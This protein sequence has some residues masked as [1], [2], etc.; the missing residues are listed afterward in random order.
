MNTY[1]E[2]LSGPDK[3][4]VYQIRPTLRIGSGKYDLSI[5]DPDLPQ[6]HSQVLLNAKNQMVLVCT[7]AVFEIRI[8]GSSVKKVALVHGMTLQIGSTHLKVSISSI[9]IIGAVDPLAPKRDPLTRPNKVRTPEDSVENTK[10]LSIVVDSPKSH[11][12]KGLREFSKTVTNETATNSFKLF[13]VPLLL[14]LETG[15]QADDEY[16]VSWGPRDF[17]PMALEFPIEFPPFPGVLFTLSPSETG[18]VVFSTKHPDFSRVRGISEST[19]VINS[20][21][22]VEAGNSTILIEYLKDFGGHDKN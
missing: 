7:N 15:P 18:Q 13:N 3:G 22:R 9:P 8:N 21:D 1:L 10:G 4:M 6:L 17:G 12:A 11:L 5:R 2:I 19:C 20:G 14:R 16:V